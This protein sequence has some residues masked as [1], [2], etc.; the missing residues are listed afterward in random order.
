[1]SLTIEDLTAIYPD[2]LLLEFTTQERE[3]AWQEIQSK[4]YINITARWHTFLNYL[5]LHTLLNYLETEQ[6]FN[7]SPQVWK[8]ADLLNFWQILSGTAIEL[9]QKRI[10]I[11]PHEEKNCSEFGVPREWVDIPDWIGNYYLA[12]EINLEQCWLRIW[13]YTTYEQLREQGKYNWLDETYYLPAEELM[14]ELTALWLMVESNSNYRRQLKPFPFGELINSK[15]PLKCFSP[16]LSAHDARTLLG[17]LARSDRGSLRLNL[18]FEEWSTLIADDRWRKK[19]YQQHKLMETPQLSKS[20]VD[21]S[22]WL[23]G[24]FTLGWQ[25]LAE[26]INSAMNANV[27]A[28]RSNS[29][30]LSSK[31]EGVKLLDLGMQLGN[32]SVALLIGM[33][34]ETENKIGVRVQLHPVGEK[35]Y[36][37]TNIKLALINHSGK[38]LQEFAARSQDELIQLKHFTCPRKKRFLIRVALN[39]YSIT[40][41]FALD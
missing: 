34:L 40:E 29:E 23:Q 41:E 32:Q 27:Y 19:L 14:E 33:T 11:I 10:I 35:N 21:L 30:S 38:I 3:K 37:P 2:Q 24:K 26:F 25:P 5:C 15:T 8:Q 9:N 7:L 6:N 39:S 22:E 12:V 20:T 18:P 17:R 36:L 31:V 1:M 13:G 28:L 16:S 4:N